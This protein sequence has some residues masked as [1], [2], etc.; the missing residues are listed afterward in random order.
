MIGVKC[1]H[2]YPLLCF[3]VRWRKNVR[4]AGQPF[5]LNAC[6]PLRCRRRDWLIAFVTA[7]NFTIVFPP[8]TG[9]GDS[10][11]AAVVTRPGMLIGNGKKPTE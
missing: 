6:A 1:G 2:L 4:A 7:G 5:S 10:R 8:C 3:L 9:I 11:L